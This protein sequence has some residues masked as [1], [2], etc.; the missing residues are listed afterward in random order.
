MANLFTRPDTFFGVC[1][2]LGQ[3]LRVNPIWFRLAFGVA[4]L[5]QPVTVIAAYFA[6]GAVVL[7]LRLLMPDATPVEVAPVPARD[8]A[9][10]A[11]TSVLANAA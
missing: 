11:E 1:E 2:A 6:L 8:G 7:V 4:L 3:D 10:D 9:N 5:W